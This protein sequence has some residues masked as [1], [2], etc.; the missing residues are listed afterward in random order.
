MTE[1]I[2]RPAPAGI[3]AV[4]AVASGL[5]ATGCCI[6]PLAL[7]VLGAG[8]AWVGA[9]TALAPYQPAFLAVGGLSVG[10]GVLQMRR[11]ARLDC[12]GGYCGTPRSRRVLKA[13]FWLSIA[14][15][16]AAIGF[17]RLAPFLLA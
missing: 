14:L 7:F 8:G 9:L 5:L 1:T 11:R 15:I 10:V 12:A 4:A 6:V 2:Q 13:A 16:V 3:A 17:D